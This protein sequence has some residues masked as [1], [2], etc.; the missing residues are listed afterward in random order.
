MNEERELPQARV[1]ERYEVD[2]PLCSEVNDCGDSN[3]QSEAEE[4]AVQSGCE[5]TA[6]ATGVS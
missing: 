1:H 2:C 3:P 4:K 6:V 5:E